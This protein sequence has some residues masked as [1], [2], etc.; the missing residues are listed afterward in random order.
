MK[1]SNVS[2]LGGAEIKEGSEVYKDT[3]EVAKVLAESGITILNGGGPGVMRAST[4]GAHLGG[5]RAIGVT[6]YPHY[7]HAHFEGRDPKN[8]FDEEVICKDYFDRTQRLL[9][10]GNVHIIFEGGTGTISEFGMS[11]ALARIHEGHNI[12]IILYGD[13][14]KNVIESFNTYLL[15]RPGEFELFRIVNTP[16]EAYYAIKELEGL[17]KPFPLP[18]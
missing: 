2:F 8:T 9:E 4:E 13:F 17:D 12:P 1:I 15:M 10:M 5:G 11:W 18:Q 3:V 14:W 16:Q 7:K 6:F